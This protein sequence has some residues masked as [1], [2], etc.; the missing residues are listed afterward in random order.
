[1]RIISNFFFSSACSSASFF[2]SS[3][4]SAAG[5]VEGGSFSSLEFGDVT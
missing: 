2:S 3:G 4:V 5:F 1:L